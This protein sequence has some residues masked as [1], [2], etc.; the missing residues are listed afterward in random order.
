MI[1]I[2]HLYNCFPMDFLKC[3]IQHGERNKYLKSNTN[4]IKTPTVC[5]LRNAGGRDK[6]KLQF[7][8]YS[9]RFSNLFFIFLFVF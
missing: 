8:F 9:L 2:Y 3:F 4:M 5:Y 6:Q 1:I 7:H